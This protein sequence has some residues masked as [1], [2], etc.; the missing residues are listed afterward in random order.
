MNKILALILLL[1]QPILADEYIR[2]GVELDV[3][4]KL[5]L[6]DPLEEEESQYIPR[7]PYKVFDF[8]TGVC[9]TNIY[10]GKTNI[11]GLESFE[12]MSCKRKE[13]L[14]RALG[15]T[16]VILRGQGHICS[17]FPLPGAKV[18]A[19]I[20]NISGYLIGSLSFF[21]TLSDCKKDEESKIRTL[22]NA[23]F[24]LR[25]QGINCAGVGSDF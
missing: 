24:E 19:Q 21:I 1:S 12:D 6:S 20:F 14:T 15:S 23:C 5:G 22:E 13:A 8:D 25:K 2:D 7:P 4:N 16:A 3:S 17:L 11:E 10:M 18:G 9:F